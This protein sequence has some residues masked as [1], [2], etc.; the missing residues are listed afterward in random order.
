MN[1]W[2]RFQ[3]L[4]LKQQIIVCKLWRLNGYSLSTG[5]LS[6]SYGVSILRSFWFFIYFQRRLFLP[7]EL[8]LLVNTFKRTQ[9]IKLRNRLSLFHEGLGRL[10]YQL[11]RWSLLF[12]FCNNQVLTLVSNRKIIIFLNICRCH[13]L[14]LG[15]QNINQLKFVIRLVFID[16]VDHFRLNNFIWFLYLSFKFRFLICFNCCPRKNLAIRLF[17]DLFKALFPASLEI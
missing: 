6:T 4:H 11:K 15:D 8:I 9:N 14:F 7:F 5:K 10:W 16:Y 12:Y 13:W 17:S 3:W 1:S 2:H